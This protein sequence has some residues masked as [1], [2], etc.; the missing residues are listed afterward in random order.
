[1]RVNGVVRHPPDLRRASNN[2]GSVPKL[3]AQS[4]NSA[5]VSTLT[6]GREDDDGGVIVVALVKGGQGT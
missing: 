2:H 6:Q 1:M 5:K 3:P 4:Q